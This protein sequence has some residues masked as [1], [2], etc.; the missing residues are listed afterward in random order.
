MEKYKDSIYSR[1]FMFREGI[2]KNT[3]KILNISRDY[4]MIECFESKISRE[5]IR[6]EDIINVVN[7]ESNLKDFNINYYVKQKTNS[8]G[9]ESYQQFSTSLRTQVVCEILKQMVIKAIIQDLYTKVNQHPVETFKSCLYFEDLEDSLGNFKQEGKILNKSN[10]SNKIL[11]INLNIYRSIIEW[12][13]YDSKRETRIRICDI[14]K[15][16]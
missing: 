1:Y 14:E 10:N 11:D 16:L 12:V 13:A 4:I 3:K 9:I 15:A 6:Y 2:F 7:S 8:E 5:I